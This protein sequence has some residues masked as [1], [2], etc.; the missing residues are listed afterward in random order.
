M[1]MKPEEIQSLQEV[2]QAMREAG[3]QGLEARRLPVCED[4]A[5]PE[6][7]FDMMTGIGVFIGKSFGWCV[8]GGETFSTG[9]G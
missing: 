6:F 2:Y 5:P 8:M 4:R 9:L 3:H 1:E 7:C